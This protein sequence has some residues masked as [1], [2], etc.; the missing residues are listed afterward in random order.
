MT[1]SI[2]YRHYAK[3]VAGTI[4]DIILPFPR[5]RDGSNESRGGSGSKELQGVRRQSESARRFEGARIPLSASGLDAGRKR[6]RQD[7]FIQELLRDDGV[8]ER[9]RVG[10]ASR[11][12]PSGHG[13]G[14]QQVQGPVQHAFGGRA[15][16]E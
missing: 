12:S 8:C 4:A 16:G 13:S 1:Q 11:R 5:R 14:V 2:S 3:R 6:D 7:L 15:L 10:V 9:D